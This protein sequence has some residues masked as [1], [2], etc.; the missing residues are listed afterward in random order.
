MVNEFV[1]KLRDDIWQ[2]AEPL[3]ESEGL[4]LV[5]IECLRMKTRWLIRIYMDKEGGVTLD[6]CAEISNQLGD[7]LDVHDLPSG[8]Y[9]LEVSSPGLDRPLVR[10]RDFIKYQ[11]CEVNVR[12]EQKIAGIRNFRGRLLEYH[13]EGDQKTLVI[14]MAS[15]V[16]RIPKD[17]VVKANLVYRF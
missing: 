16:Y 4:E 15:K 17:L 1:K 9:T 14:E 13:E 6:D 5:Q 11:G 10:D 12:L 2:L 3:I 7:V 8:P